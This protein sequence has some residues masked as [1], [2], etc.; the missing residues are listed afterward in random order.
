MSKW[1]WPVQQRPPSRAWRN[2]TLALQGIVSED[3][4]LYN[5]LGP[6]RAKTNTHQS[7][8]W[9]L[10]VTTLSL[11]RHH[12]G[13]WTKHRAINYDRLRFKIMGAA[14]EEPQ[15]ITHKAEG[16]N[17]RRHIDLTEVHAIKEGDIEG[18]MIHPTAYT[19]QR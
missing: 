6:W 15:R 14:S 3:G 11:Y 4:D 18:E 19:H 16:V 13:V 7:T 1:N 2:W 12:E 8:E 17:L 5:S 10:D 9:N